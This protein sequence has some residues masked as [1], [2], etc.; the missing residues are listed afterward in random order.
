VILRAATAD[1]E[2]A[3]A[4]QAT[5]PARFGHPQGGLL[6]RK[7]ILDF[8][9]K[10]QYQ[11]ELLCNLDRVPESGALVVVSFPKPRTGSGFPA[12]VFAILP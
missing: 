9:G 2:G 4:F 7:L 6:N 10:D 1:R 12:R 11:I 8:R 3:L 5:A